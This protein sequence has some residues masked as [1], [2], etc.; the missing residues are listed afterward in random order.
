MIGIL[1]GTALGFALLALRSGE[2]GGGR[3]RRAPL[4]NPGAVGACCVECK[5]AQDHGSMAY[6]HTCTSCGT[7][8]IVPRFGARDVDGWC[9]RQ[10]RSE[11]S[12]VVDFC[13]GPAGELQ[14][15][16]KAALEALYPTDGYGDK[17]DWGRVAYDGGPLDQLRSRVTCRILAAAAN[18]N[19]QA[20]AHTFRALGHT[21]KG[22]S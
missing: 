14:P 22:Q 5:T 8:R 18:F 9:L 10:F 2:D 20:S 16:V 4:G 17:I 7:L 19:D 12:S 15:V 21:T 11:P 3:D 6:G 1:A 13:R